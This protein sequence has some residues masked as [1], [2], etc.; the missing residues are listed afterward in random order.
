[1]KNFLEFFTESAHITKIYWEKIKTSGERGTIAFP[2]VL[3]SDGKIYTSKEPAV[4]HKTPGMSDYGG[5]GFGSSRPGTEQH[6]DWDLWGEIDDLQFDGSWAVKSMLDHKEMW[7]E[8]PAG[9]RLSE[10]RNNLRSN[11]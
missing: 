10:I 1:M 5:K 6:W 11:L 9:T 8:Y 3:F 7:N 4:Y 2:I